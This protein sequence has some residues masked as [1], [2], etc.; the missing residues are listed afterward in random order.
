MPF[1]TRYTLLNN[2]VDQNEVG[3]EAFFE[4]YEP[5]I[6]LRGGD[7]GLTDTE[8]EELVQEVMMAFFRGAKSFVYNP[9]LGRFRTYLKTIVDRRSVDI[10]RKRQQGTVDIDDVD[11][12]DLQPE[13]APDDL[14]EAAFREKMLESAMEQL[15]GESH[16]N[17]WASFYQTSIEKR[18]AKEVAEELGISVNS[19]YFAK[20]RVMTKL[21][22]MI[23]TMERL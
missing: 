23:E 4:L 21:K 1:T 10:L 12:L 13:P 9:E 3:W 22:R 11:H 18:K 16:P 5:L 19:V 20:H 15:E 17:T 6:R 7:F 14:W 2:L 8:K